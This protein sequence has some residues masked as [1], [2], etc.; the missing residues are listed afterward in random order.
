MDDIIFGSTNK[1]LCEDFVY[2]MQRDFE[3]SIIGELNYFVG[4][5]VKQMDH[6]T[7]LHQTKYYKELLKKFEMEKKQR[8]CNS[9]G[10]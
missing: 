9:Y 1:S 4:F 8:V 3:M 7:F 5:K 2:K 6:G 10:Y